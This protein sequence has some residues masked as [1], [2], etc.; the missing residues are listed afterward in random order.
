MQPT[1]FWLFMGSSQHLSIYVYDV[2]QYLWNSRKP[3]DSHH[4]KNGILV[5]QFAKSFLWFSFP[6]RRES[7]ILPVA[8]KLL[9]EVSWDN[10][11]KY[12]YTALLSFISFLM[13]FNLSL[14][15]FWSCLQDLYLSWHKEPNSVSRRNKTYLE[16]NLQKHGSHGHTGLS[17]FFLIF[18]TPFWTHFEEILVFKNYL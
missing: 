5:S 2:L 14:S 15:N 4:K 17:E 9:P 6:L 12:N 7:Y 18:K 16:T 1:H 13:L 10:G 11:N 8:F 3:T